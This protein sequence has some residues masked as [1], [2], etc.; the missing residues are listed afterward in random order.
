LTPRGPARDTP[1]GACRNFIPGFRIHFHFGIP[2]SF[3]FRPQPTFHSYSRRFLRFRFRRF[4]RFRHI[5]SISSSVES[6]PPVDQFPCSG[7]PHSF[8]RVPDSALHFIN[9]YINL[10]FILLH[11]PFSPN[12]FCIH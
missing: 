9:T 4:R 10:H 6:A 1:Y 2:H 7:I 12:N 11:T 8:L 5:P 3:L